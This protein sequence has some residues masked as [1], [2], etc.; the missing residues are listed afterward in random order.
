MVEGV[1]LLQLD[2]R[3]RLHRGFAAG[4]A[5]TFEQRA[6]QQRRSGC[7]WIPHGRWWLEESADGR[8][9]QF[10]EQLPGRPAA[11]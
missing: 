9:G 4:T 10:A 3:V 1:G 5:V 2:A 6:M 11:G 7:R 8:V